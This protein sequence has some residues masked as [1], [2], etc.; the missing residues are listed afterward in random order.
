MDCALSPGSSAVRLDCTRTIRAF[1][2]QSGNNFFKDGNHTDILAAV[3]DSQTME[4]RS[5][6]ED[7]KYED[8][9]LYNYRVS[10][11]RL[12]STDPAGTQELALPQ[13]VLVEFEWAWHAALLKGNAGQSF[14][15]P[16]GYLMTWDNEQQK[17]TPLVKDLVLRMGDDETLELPQG[18]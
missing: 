14:S 10:N 18:P 15:V 16:F 4:L 17:S 9:S 5:F 2:Y 8:G 1:E 11:G 13:N 6:S 7:K 12:I 3:C